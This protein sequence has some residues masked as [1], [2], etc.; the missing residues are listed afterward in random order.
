MVHSH[1][2]QHWTVDT[3]LP[4]GLCT[5]ASDPKERKDSWPPSLV[6]VRTRGDDLEWCAKASK[7]CG[8]VGWGRRAALQ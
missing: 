6:V 2:H 1:L 3:L 7:G 4:A 8:G 5:V